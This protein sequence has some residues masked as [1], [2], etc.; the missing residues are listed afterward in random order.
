MAATVDE[1]SGGR[2]VLGLGA[3]WNK[4]EF[5]AFGL[6]YD[7]RVLRFAEA[8]EVV[9]LLLSGERVT[10]SGRFWQVEDAVLLPKPARR[11]K[12]MVGSSGERILALSL[13]HVDAWNIWF[14]LYGNTPEGFAVE[15]AKV[16]AAA[17]RVGR[18]PSEIERSA[19]VLV[20][21]DRSASERPVPESV[22][23]LEG[24][25]DRIATGLRQLA[26]AGADEAIL[27]VDP[28]TER[29][30]Q[31]LGEALSSLDG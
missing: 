4:A 21:L 26:E 5:R 31:A 14:D 8:F 11:P 30:V 24:T 13:P 3:G 1:V 17:G 15:S 2:L 23:P 25:M 18:D 27:V 12:L 7:H 16:T 29:S 19:C 10:V 6:P 28:I 9:R 20:V 22:I